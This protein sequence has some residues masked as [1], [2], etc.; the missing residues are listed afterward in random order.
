MFRRGLIGFLLIFA[1][2]AI[3]NAAVY[4]PTTPNTRL[5]DV[6]AQYSPHG[7]KTLDQT[8]IAILK[9]NPR[10]FSYHNINGLMTGFYLK[11]PN[12]QEIY[13]L[14]AKEALDSINQQNA[15]W[16]HIMALQHE[17]NAH[18]TASHEITPETSDVTM[19]SSSQSVVLQ[20]NQAESEPAPMP[21]IIQK[22]TTKAPE[23]KKDLPNVSLKSVATAAIAPASS[24]QQAAPTPLTNSQ[25]KQLTKEETYF[26]LKPKRIL[27]AAGLLFL[28]LCVVVLIRHKRAA[29]KITQPSK[30]SV[31]DFAGD[32][33]LDTKLDLCRGYLEQGNLKDM[34]LLVVDIL[35]EGDARQTK[36]SIEMLREL[37]E[38]S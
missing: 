22:V 29:P 9:K 15:D 36:Q 28:L 11:I 10:A 3:A 14:T 33:Q 34:L 27:L 5:H 17:A 20:D 32:N 6:A 35:E 30:I 21:P 7:E 16:A 38:K 13:V 8:M 37:A 24:V 4:G 2:Y 1:G 26:D 25:I 18:K 12:N 23:V 19:P 31:E